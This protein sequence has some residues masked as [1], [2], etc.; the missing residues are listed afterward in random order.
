[1]EKYSYIDKP[2]KQ[3]GAKILNAVLIAIIILLVI[4]LII[5]TTTLTTITVD[6][7]SMFPTLVDGDRLI[8]IKYGYTLQQ[9]DII[10][11][12]RE[13]HNNVKRILGL[14]GDVIQFDL[15]NMIWVVN[16]TPYEEEYIEDGYS[17]NYFSMSSKDVLNEIFSQEGL[18]VPQGKMF[19][20]GDNRNIQGGGISMDSH[21]YGVWDTST[22]M[23]KVIKIY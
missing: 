10:V 17:D 11:F 6:G 16:G 18:V 15:E 12:T 1:M 9:G 19:V 3:T 14:E 5:F 4:T 7:K 2:K 20:L 23:G 8:L 21:T 22:I 13:G